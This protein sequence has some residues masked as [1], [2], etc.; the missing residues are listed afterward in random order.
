MQNDNAHILVE[1]V[2]IAYGDFVVQQ[3]LG[4]TVERGDIF[5]IMGG[6]GSMP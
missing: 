1:D 6:S 5:I 4:F 2:T 3:N